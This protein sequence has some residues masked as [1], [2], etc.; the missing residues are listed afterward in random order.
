MPFELSILLPLPALNLTEETVIV[1]GKRFQTSSFSQ[2]HNYN[3][4]LS[5]SNR[6][7]QTSSVLEFGGTFVDKYIEYKEK[8]TMP[9]CLVIFA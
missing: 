3:M 8:T 4:F 9:Y 6:N 1:E 5:P 7:R 2:H